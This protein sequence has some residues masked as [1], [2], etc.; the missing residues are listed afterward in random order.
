M[1]TSGAGGGK[2]DD[3]SLSSSTSLECYVS[4]DHQCDLD[5]LKK[6]KKMLMLVEG[7]WS[8]SMT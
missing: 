6:G 3:D 1:K 7:K 2:K 8:R 5:W 4:P